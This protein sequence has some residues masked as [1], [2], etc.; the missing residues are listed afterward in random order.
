MI[1]RLAAAALLLFGVVWSIGFPKKA[2]FDPDMVES[3]A[4]A[5]SFLGTG[6]IVLRSNRWQRLTSVLSALLLWSLAANVFLVS[7]CVAL[8]V[9]LTK[10]NAR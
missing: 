10:S 9:L 1:R 4:I 5:I 7:Q 2:T 3:V 8:A 6:L